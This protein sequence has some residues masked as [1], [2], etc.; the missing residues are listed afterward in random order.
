MLGLTVLGNDAIYF[1]I[2]MGPET[3]TT[4]ERAQRH[5][6]G[7]A[8]KLDLILAE[9]AVIRRRVDQISTCPIAKW[10]LSAD[11]RIG[12]SPP[13]FMAKVDQCTTT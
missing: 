10:P 4:A 6:N 7:L 9:V 1:A 3:K 8:R 5:R 13:P 12:R 2:M 11:P